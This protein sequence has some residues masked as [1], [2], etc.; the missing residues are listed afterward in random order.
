M[1]E[2]ICKY[3]IVKN[4]QEKAQVL[5]T[6]RKNSIE[7][8]DYKYP[9]VIGEEE[10]R[11]FQAGGREAPFKPYEDFRTDKKYIYQEQKIIEEKVFQIQDSHGGLKEVLVLENG[12]LESYGFLEVEEL[13]VKWKGLK[14]LTANDMDSISKLIKRI[15][16]SDYYHNKN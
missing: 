7:Q 16:N 13:P 12:G 8:L 3:W 9:F 11:I 5:K 14:K 1:K 15:E 10:G 6:L 4:D 2:V